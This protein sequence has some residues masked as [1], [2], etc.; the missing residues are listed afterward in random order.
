M[1][2]FWKDIREGNPLAII[3]LVGVTLLLLMFALALA[4]TY[5]PQTLCR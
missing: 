1:K 5:P 3:T 4:I 2:G